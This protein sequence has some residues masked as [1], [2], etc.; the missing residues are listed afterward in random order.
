MSFMVAAAF[1][2][3]FLYILLLG[4][5]ASGFLRSRFSLKARL[6]ASVPVS[7]IVCARNEAA[8]IAQCIRSVIAQDY[9]PDLIE[10]IIVNDASSDNTLQEAE[11]ALQA[12]RFSYRI[13]PNN[14]RKGKKASITVALRL[15][16]H[17]LIVLRDADT[18]TESKTWLKSVS[19]MH[20]ASGADLIIGPVEI[21]MEPG[22]LAA[23]QV[24]ESSLLNLLSC[25]S[26]R[27]GVPFLSSSANL[28]F[29]KRIFDHVGGFSSHAHISSGDDVLFLEDIKKTSHR[30]IV[31]L[32]SR[33]AIIF[34]FPER[35]L[36]AILNQRIRWS[37]KIRQNRNV[38]N[39]IIAL[40]VFLVNLIFIAALFAV[41]TR[42][43]IFA[44][45]II[46]LKILTDFL[47]LF[48]ATSFSGNRRLLWYTLPLSLLYPLYVLIIAPAAL[49]YKPNWK[50]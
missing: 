11:N 21:K 42:L 1:L 15:A 37:S 19:D 35:S 12:A 18:F 30:G 45:G 40:L 31:Y 26:A 20:Q 44:I 10:L 27:Y 22:L 46:M 28:S 7:I 17:P 4:W 24:A 25:G 13:I 32:K 23:L 29:T 38:L 50:N 9:P 34:T 14:E 43:R 49:F 47:L 36:K 3:L 33:A 16:L 48:I 41:Q 8:H 5:L 6:P 39:F 2:L